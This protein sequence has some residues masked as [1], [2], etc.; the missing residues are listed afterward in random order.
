VRVKVEVV[1]APHP[2]Q[3]VEAALRS[4]GKQLA[5]TAESVSVEVRPTAQP[6]APRIAVLAFE[7]RRAAQYKVVDDIYR[8]VKD[9][10]WQFYE[11]ITIRF[12]KG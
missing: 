4:A 5:L 9:C 11:D 3:A 10:A 8:T 6:T 1:C 2:R 12:P 7:M